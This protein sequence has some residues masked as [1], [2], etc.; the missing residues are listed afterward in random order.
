M[1]RMFQMK[2]VTKVWLIFL[3]FAIGGGVG[4]ELTKLGLLPIPRVEW[5]IPIVDAGQYIPSGSVEDGTEVVLVYVGASTCGWSNVPE[6]PGLIRDIK[7]NLLE[8]TRAEG[9]SFSVLG[10]ARDAVAIDGWRHLEKY[11]R[12][13]EIA[14]GHGWANIGIQR[15]LFGEIAGPLATP[16]VLVVERDISSGLGYTSVEN[17]RLITRKVGVDQISKWADSGTLLPGP[18]SRYQVQRGS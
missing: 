17:E 3:L 12:F 14:T 7:L 11:G 8:R 10:I 4:F 6:L 15:Y 16:Q 13:D 9:K 2:G 18:E 5:T 1:N